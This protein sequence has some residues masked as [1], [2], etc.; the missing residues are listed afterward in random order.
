LHPDK[1]LFLNFQTSQDLLINI[2]SVYGKGFF[3]WEEE[4]R[5]YHLSGSDD[6][7][8]LTSGTQDVN[9]KLSS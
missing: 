9:H 4:N 2:V 1:E 7:L 6:R 3:R 5:K 8:T